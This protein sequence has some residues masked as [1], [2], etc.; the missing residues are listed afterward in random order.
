MR[1]TSHFYTYTTRAVE[2]QGVLKSSAVRVGVSRCGGEASL[3]WNDLRL[4]LVF[5]ESGG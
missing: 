4:D 3:A 5:G 1:D 2:A